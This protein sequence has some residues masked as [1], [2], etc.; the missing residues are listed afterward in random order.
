MFWDL[1]WSFCF[2]QIK[3]QNSGFWKQ[4]WKYDSVSVQ[5]I[6]IGLSSGTWN[7]L[8][9]SFVVPFIL[10][11]TY[12]VFN[13]NISWRCRRLKTA[14]WSV[15]IYSG[16]RSDLSSFTFCSRLFLLTELT[17]Y[18]STCWLCVVLQPVVPHFFFYFILIILF[19]FCNYLAF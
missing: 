17:L 3:K 11:W 9:T 6:F 16:Q 7:L 19:N 13:T 8:Q 4:V 12:E 1:N 15:E 2:I 18:G 14:R 10:T 5:V